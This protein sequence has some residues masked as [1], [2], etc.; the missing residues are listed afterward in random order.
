MKLPFHVGRGR[1]VTTQPPKHL[2]GDSA[3]QRKPRGQA[4]DHSDD[5]PALVEVVEVPVMH[6]EGLRFADEVQHL[7]SQEAQ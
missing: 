2:A 6:S 1:V 7:S 3:P 5:G 4:L